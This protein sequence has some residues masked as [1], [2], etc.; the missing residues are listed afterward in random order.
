MTFSKMAY[1]LFFSFMSLM[2]WSQTEDE[3]ILKKMVLESF[4]DIWSD[5]DTATIS[6]YYTDDFL[7]L[8][9]GELWTVDTIVHYVLGAKKRSPKVER[10]NRIEFI[11]FRIEGDRAWIAYHNY[12]Q[13]FLEGELIRDLHWLESAT[14][15]RREG[16]WKFDMLHS[17]RVKWNKG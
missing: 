1:F 9:H 11:D 8:E 12:A 15:I 3:V 14:A 4:D 10:K 13:L 2:V 5:L 17:T 6:K 16:V 7:L